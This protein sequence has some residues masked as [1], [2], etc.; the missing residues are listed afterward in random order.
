[1]RTYRYAFYNDS[2]QIGFLVIVQS[3]L[4]TTNINVVNTPTFRTYHSRQNSRINTNT[5]L[6]T[7]L[8]V[9]SDPKIAA[10]RTK[11]KKSS[12]KLPPEVIYLLNI[13]NSVSDNE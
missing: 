1:V 9:I 7:F 11:F 2:Q 12:T 13:E 10:L 5:D 3:G 4:P 6:L 8:L